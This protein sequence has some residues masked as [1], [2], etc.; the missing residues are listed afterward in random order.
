MAERKISAYSRPLAI[1]ERPIAMPRASC[2]S[3]VLSLLMSFFVYAAWADEP[4][5]K[6]AKRNHVVLIGNTLAERMQY[7]GHFETLLHSRFPDLELVVRD[8]GWSADVLML[9]LRSQDFKDHGH[10]LEDHK[11]DVILAFFGFNE[12]FAGER[13]LSKF[14]H[15]LEKFIGDTLPAKYNGSGPPHIVMFTPTL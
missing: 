13:G 9:R 12:S 3:L 7:F 8:L 4:K 6:L 10:T 15:D 1:V 2:S 14:E 11:T 5:L